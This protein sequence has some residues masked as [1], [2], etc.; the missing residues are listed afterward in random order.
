M[1]KQVGQFGV[2]ALIG[3]LGALFLISFE[4]LVHQLEHLLWHTL[5]DAFSAD[6]SSPLW[7]LVILGGGGIVVGLI[8]RF[9][10]AGHDPATEGLFGEPLEISAVVGLIVAAL[11]SLSIGASLGP[12]APLLGATGAVLAWTANKRGL[13]QE[14]LVSLG[15]AGLLG[16]MFGAPVG[17]AFAFIELVPLSGKALYDRLVPLFI[18]SSAGALTIT[19]VVGRPRFLAPFPAA[20]NFMAIDI[21]SAAAIGVVGALAGLVVGVGLRSLHPLATRLP[22]VLRMTLGGVALAV[23]AM[24]AGEI[25]LFSGQREIEVLVRDFA[26]FTGID[27]LWIAVLKLASLLVAVVVGF[28]GGRIFPAVFVGVAIGAVIHHYIPDIPFALA[29]GAATVGFVLAF[30]RVWFLTLM[31]VAMIVGIEWLPVLGV[32]L[33]AAHLIVDRQKLTSGSR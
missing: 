31:L 14:G 11:F 25:V 7:M 20:R 12:E 5:P 17:A 22:V 6:H 13:P 9:A 16:A 32:A 18:A 27:L 26:S 33:V 24:V 10:N 19:A 21:L 2:A 29:A 30:I 15:I 23:M 1:N 4:W 8:V 28:R 3:V